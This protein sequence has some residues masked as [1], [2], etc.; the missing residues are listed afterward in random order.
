MSNIYPNREL[1]YYPLSKEKFN[2]QNYFYKKNQP[3]NPHLTLR[4][5]HQAKKHA[6][7]TILIRNNNLLNQAFPSKNLINLVSPQ[8]INYNLQR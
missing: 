4:L 8:I 7:L 6:L 1:E 5:F 3:I 2:Q